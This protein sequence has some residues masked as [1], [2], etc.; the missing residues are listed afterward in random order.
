[1]AAFIQ[2]RM[3]SPLRGTLEEE[4]KVQRPR[5]GRWSHVLKRDDH[6]SK[7]IRFLWWT[8][9]EFAEMEALEGSLAMYY[10]SCYAILLIFLDPRGEEIRIIYD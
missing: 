5:Q 9:L 8:A 4:E 2:I 1:M 3:F 10:G 7:C 6:E